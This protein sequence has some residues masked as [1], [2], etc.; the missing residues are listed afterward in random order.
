M[1]KEN[2][3]PRNKPKNTCDQKANLD[4]YRWSDVIIIIIIIILRIL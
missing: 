1:N 2:Y 4:G 3:K